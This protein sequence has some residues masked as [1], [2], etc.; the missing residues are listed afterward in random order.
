M[1]KRTLPLFLLM[2]MTFVVVA[3]GTGKEGGSKNAGDE[4]IDTLTLTLKGD[5]TLYGLACDGCNDTVL[6]LL[7]VSDTAANPDTFYILEA[8]RRQR[9]LGSLSVGDNIAVVRNDSDRTVADFVIDLED[10]QNTWYYEMLPN[11]R[12]RADMTGN[13]ES[14]RISNLPDSVK[15]LL[16][17]PR[18][19]MLQI[20]GDHTVV[21]WGGRAPHGDDDS[22]VDYPQ[23]KHYGQW[24]LMNG[25][26]LLTVTA[27]DSLGQMACV[28]T[29]TVD[30][31]HLNAD[32]LALRFSEGQRGYYSQKKHGN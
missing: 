10:L 29:D 28:E 3:C 31:L 20:K 32:T 9:V 8:T 25:R 19:Y 16:S 17:I 30:V 2:F 14:Q 6:V 26:L 24:F 5:S 4:E 13:T 7:P 15:R 18:E 11:L 12:Q 27:I 1:K 22:I 23:A 21:S